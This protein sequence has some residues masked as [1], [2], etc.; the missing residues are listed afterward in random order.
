MTLAGMFSWRPVPGLSDYRT[1][2]EGLYLCGAGTWPGGYVT[3]IPG[4]NASAAVLSD[5]TDP[6][7]A[8]DDLMAGLS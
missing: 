8:G 3:G 6:S 7:R 4:H 2:V 5:L 1:P